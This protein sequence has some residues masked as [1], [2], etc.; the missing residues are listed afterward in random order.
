MTLVTHRLVDL[1]PIVTM[2]Y[3]LVYQ[4]IKVILILDAV[5][6]VF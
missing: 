2:E 6:N 5:Q 3:A 4:N 1:I